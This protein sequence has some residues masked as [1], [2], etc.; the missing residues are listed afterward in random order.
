METPTNADLL[1]RVEAIEA[2]V[3]H[4]CALAEQANGAWFVLKLLGS[5]AVSL[6]AFWVAAHNWWVR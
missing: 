4:L 6:T 1:V 3:D 5:I 2:K